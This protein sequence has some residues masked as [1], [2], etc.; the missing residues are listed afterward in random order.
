MDPTTNLLLT[1]LAAAGSQV[2]QHTVQFH[3][4]LTQ[5]RTAVLQN[6]YSICFPTNRTVY[7]V[8]VE[9]INGTFMDL[10]AFRGKLLLVVNVATYSG[11]FTV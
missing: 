9:Q 4:N 7:N 8:V 1:A 11:L 3:T 2:L 5:N 6:R 10:S